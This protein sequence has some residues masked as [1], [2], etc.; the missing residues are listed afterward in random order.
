MFIY[1]FFFLFPTFFLSFFLS[2]FS[3]F[4]HSYLQH[5]IAPR[6]HCISFRKLGPS[7]SILNPVHLKSSIK[8][9]KQNNCSN[10]DD[11]ND[12]NDDIDIDNSYNGT[13]ND[14]N[15]KSINK[16]NNKNKNKGKNKNEISKGTEYTNSPWA[17]RPLT[18]ESVD[19]IDKTL[20]PDYNI[21]NV[22]VK[23]WILNKIKKVLNGDVLAAEYV[24]LG[25]LSKLY[26]RENNETLLLGSLSLNL[27]LLEVGDER[28]KALR[29]VLT[30]FVPLCIQVD[31]LIICG[32]IKNRNFLNS[33]C[34]VVLCCIVFF[35]LALFHSFSLFLCLSHCLL[36]SLSLSLS[37]SLPLTLSLFILEFYSQY[38]DLC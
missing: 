16:I 37:V 31:R 22:E 2:F 3:F 9:K 15:K 14:D 8:S 33:L 23:K 17:L 24:I 28:I 5:S 1:I 18:P 20:I 32:K 19:K 38:L 34:C 13:T 11:D 25:I 12:N 21:N 29:D 10:K 7:F 30:E 6:I 4:F 26:H 36:L 35:F 27:C